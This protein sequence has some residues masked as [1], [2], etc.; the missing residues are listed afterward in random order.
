MNMHSST[1]IANQFVQQNQHI[2][3]HF[4]LWRFLFMCVKCDST[5]QKSWATHQIGSNTIYMMYVRHIITT[6]LTEGILYFN[7]EFIFFYWLTELLIS[8]TLLHV[9][10]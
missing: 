9:Q 1:S 10:L 8:Q 7:R 6:E 3:S 2:L 5:L 4:C